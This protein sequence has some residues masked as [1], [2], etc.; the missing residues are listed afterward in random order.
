MDELPEGYRPIGPLM[1]VNCEEEGCMDTE[2]VL[3]LHEQRLAKLEGLAQ[4]GLTEDARQAERFEQLRESQARM[5][6]MLSRVEHEAR[7]AK[8][9]AH[10][11]SYDL[12]NGL[13]SLVQSIATRVGVVETDLHAHEASTPNEAERRREMR[14]EIDASAAKRAG[15]GHRTIEIGIAV[16]IAIITLSE[17]GALEWIGRLFGG[18]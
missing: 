13:K 10:R 8:E 7:E 16:I 9:T 14:E 11:N 1:R 3:Q 4:I 6:K 18:G 2:D 17:A 12:N 5:E 15:R